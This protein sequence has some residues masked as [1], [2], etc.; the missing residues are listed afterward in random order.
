MKMDEGIDTGPLLSQRKVSLQSDETAG[1]LSEKLAQLG[2]D[3]LI[4]TLPAYFSGDLQPY[5]QEGG[6]TYAP[7]LKKLDGQLDF[8]QSAE[9]LEHKIRAYDPWPGTF[10]DWQNGRLK[11]LKAHPVGGSSAEIGSEGQPGQRTIVQEHPAIFTGDGL[12]LLEELQPAGKKPM[13]GSV[14]LRG[15]RN[16][17]DG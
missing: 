11:I 2:A 10:M 9:A 3:L 16:W 4:E 8:T 14:F 15:S 7:L 6:H 1:C 13:P 12:L 5:A 17:I